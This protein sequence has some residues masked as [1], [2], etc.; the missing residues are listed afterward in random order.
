MTRRGIGEPD[1]RKWYHH[2]EAWAWLIGM[3]IAIA[4]I[5]SLMHDIKQ[6]LGCAQ[7][8]DEELDRYRAHHDPTEWI[9]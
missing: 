8:S 9:R 4:A 1:R 3:C 6:G 7:M 5:N 2:P